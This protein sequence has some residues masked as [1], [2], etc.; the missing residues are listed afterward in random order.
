[1]ILHSLVKEIDMR[2][3]IARV[4]KV[5]G[6]NWYVYDDQ[7]KQFVGSTLDKG[8]SKDDAREKARL[9]NSQQELHDQMYGSEKKS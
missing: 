7:M 3:C 4:G 5:K 8:Q 9:L 1:M 2:Y 6:Y